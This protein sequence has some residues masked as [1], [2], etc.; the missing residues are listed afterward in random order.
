MCLHP[1]HGLS[2]LGFGF[3]PP[4]QRGGVGRARR[5]RHGDGGSGEGDGGGCGGGEGGEGGG[6]NC[7]TKDVDPS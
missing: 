6:W 2:P 7:T 4:R 1:R 5:T 3:H